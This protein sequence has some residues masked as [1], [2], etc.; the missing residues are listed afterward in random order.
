MKKYD[1][2]CVAF[3]VLH[4]FAL[5]NVVV[6]RSIKTY[7]LTGGLFILVIA[8][9]EKLNHVD[10]REKEGRRWQAGTYLGFGVGTAIMRT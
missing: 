4:S 2:W 7:A 9:Y 10:I 5:K 6:E 8:G 3:F 1:T